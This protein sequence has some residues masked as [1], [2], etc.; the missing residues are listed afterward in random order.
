MDWYDGEF[1]IPERIKQLADGG[2]AQV[3]PLAAIVLGTEG[4]LLVSPSQP[5]KLTQGMNPANLASLESGPVNSYQQFVEACLGTGV[6][7]KRLEESLAISETLLLSNTAWRLP[8]T[9]LR[10]DSQQ[11]QFPGHPEANRFLSRVYREGWHIG[12]F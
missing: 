4:T 11:A 5:P 9:N 8:G 2:T 10:W 1:R 7:P 6:P 12:P 3:P